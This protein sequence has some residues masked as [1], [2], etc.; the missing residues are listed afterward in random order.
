MDVKC[1]DICR[2]GA[3]KHISSGG[4]HGGIP[5]VLLGSART[6]LERGGLGK[7]IGSRSPGV[8]ISVTTSEVIPYRGDVSRRTQHLRIDAAML[9]DTMCGVRNVFI[10][11]NF[12]VQS[13]SRPFGAWASGAIVDLYAKGGKVP[14]ADE[15]ETYVIRRIPNSSG[16]RITYT[17]SGGKRV[18][19][20]ASQLRPPSLNDLKTDAVEWPWVRTTGP[21]SLLLKLALAGAHVARYSRTNVPIEGEVGAVRRKAPT[22]IWVCIVEE[23]IPNNN[24]VPNQKT[25]GMFQATEAPHITGA[26]LNHQ[27]QRGHM[28]YADDDAASPSMNTDRRVGGMNRMPS[29]EQTLVNVVANALGI[30]IIS[31]FL[32][33]LAVGARLVYV[34]GWKHWVY[35]CK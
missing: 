35:F 21:P 17:G 2:V 20:G 4:A 7:L 26:L 25:S 33:S 9:G 11:A 22:P 5:D 18:Y 28:D 31:A 23:V 1:T 15:S 16:K 14:L 12:R 29:V 30:Y 27:I 3:S 13:L 19:S 24:R 10:C 32:G 6:A 8:S 34:R